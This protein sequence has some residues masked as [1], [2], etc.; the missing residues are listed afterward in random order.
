MLSDASQYRGLLSLCNRM[1]LLFCLRF[2]ETKAVV[3]YR[4]GV[5]PTL[6]LYL[7]P[8]SAELIHVFFSQLSCALE[9]LRENLSSASHSPT[10]KSFHVE[11]VLEF[12]DFDPVVSAAIDA[13][14]HGQVLGV[15]RILACEHRF[16]VVKLR[17]SFFV[18]SAVVLSALPFV[19]HYS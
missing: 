7:V 18:Q 5:A 17:K 1:P 14:H 12:N 3:W 2:G 19:G 13:M 6:M 10:I 15:G 9:K 11:L 8:L 16:F 4:I